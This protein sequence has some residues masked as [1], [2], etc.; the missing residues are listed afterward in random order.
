[1][2]ANSDSEIMIRRATAADAG[3]CGAICFAAFDAI[4][5]KHGFACALPSAEVATR[6]LTMMFSNPGFY[7]VVAE[8]GGRLI[9]SNCL[10]ER[11][12]VAG[13]GPITVDP[14]TQNH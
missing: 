14:G 13:I 4:S 5:S 1:M 8:T 12:I 6:S 11:A 7:C 2:T 3:V 9:G 10:D